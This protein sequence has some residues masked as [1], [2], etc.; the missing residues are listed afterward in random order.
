[1]LGKI[2]VMLL[3][4]ALR[5]KRSE[6]A[7]V[8]IL[9]RRFLEGVACYAKYWPGQVRVLT[10]WSDEP[11]L[12]PD[13]VTVHEAD[14]PFAIEVVDDLETAVVS[15]A[16]EASVILASHTRRGASVM[17]SVRAAV[18]RPVVL[19]SINPYRTRLQIVR[20]M[21][22]NV[23]RRWVRYRKVWRTEKVLRDAA[24]A[25]KGIQCNGMPAFEAYR[26]L[27][28]NSM[29]FFDN[30]MTREMFLSDADLEQ[31]LATISECR[32]LRLAYSGRLMA[33][34]G[35]DHLPRVMRELNKRGVE[36]TLDICGGGP[37]EQTLRKLI[38]KEQLTDA[39]R[40]RG[41]LDRRQELVPY[42]K[43]DVDL[44]LCCHRQGDPSHT[45]LDTMACGVLTVGYDNDALAGLVRHTGLNWATPMDDPGK[46]AAK[47][48][49]IDARRD[50]LARHSRGVL[51]FARQHD[52]EST[53]KK[54][55]DHLLMCAG[56]QKA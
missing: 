20:A 8:P 51:A 5:A 37:L 9:T 47:I 7:E 2:P 31:R 26:D 50:E 53:F 32:P 43:H 35:V 54:R 48:Q 6:S 10:D 52:F 39:I 17:N 34:K 14:Y 27:N 25:A 45:Y 49:S 55:I 40:L 4:P 23:L 38:D 30:R 56:L 1:M 19:T 11:S 46:L 21:T 18:S 28:A 22:P 15:R 12:E 36:A 29:L 16:N 42:M 44:F 33:I 41:V 24:E 13:P 3:V